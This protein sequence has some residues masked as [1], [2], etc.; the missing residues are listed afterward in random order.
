MVTQ[1]GEGMDTMTL[2]APGSGGGTGTDDN[3]G[4]DSGG[5]D[6]TDTGGGDTQTTPQ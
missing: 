3:S 5:T 6:S 2:A 1:S 4:G